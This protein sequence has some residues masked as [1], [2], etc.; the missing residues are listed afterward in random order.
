MRQPGREY[1]PGMGSTDH[2]PERLAEHNQYRCQHRRAM[3]TPVTDEVEDQTG[4]DKEIT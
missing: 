2:E 4:D 1:Q 3:R